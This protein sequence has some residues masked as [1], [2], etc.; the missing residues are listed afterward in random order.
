MRCKS[1]GCLITRLASH[2]GLPAVYY[3]ATL[4]VFYNCVRLCTR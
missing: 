3:L 4:S 2:A 1:L